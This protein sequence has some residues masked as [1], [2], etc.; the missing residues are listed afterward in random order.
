VEEFIAKTN[1][2]IVSHIII[3]I[4]GELSLHNAI[5]IKDGITINTALQNWIALRSGLSFWPHIFLI[6]GAEA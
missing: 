6:A 3:A 2:K 1:P 5:P 4:D